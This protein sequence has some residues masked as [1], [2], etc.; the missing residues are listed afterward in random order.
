MLEHMGYLDASA[1]IAQAI[2]KVVAAGPDNASNSVPHKLDVCSETHGETLG[3][4]VSFG[5]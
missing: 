5:S 4:T 3:G 1:A 2:E